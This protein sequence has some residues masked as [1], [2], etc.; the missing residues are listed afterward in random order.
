MLDW[1]II[2]ALTDPQIFSMQNSARLIRA[3]YCSGLAQSF[4]IWLSELTQGTYFI[5]RSN[6]DEYG[7]DFMI[8]NVTDYILNFSIIEGLT[9]NE[10]IFFYKTKD[11]LK[12]FIYNFEDR[13]IVLSPT[14]LTEGNAPSVNRAYS[15]PLYVYERE[16]KMKMRAGAGQEYTIFSTASHFVREI[17]SIQKDALYIFRYLGSHSPNVDIAL[18]IR[19]NANS[20]FLFDCTE[21]P[22]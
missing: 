11:Y 20:N 15:L 14:I 18:P 5:A 19:V 13:E 6:S 22:T 8:M 2:L 10:V 17:A 7:N 1:E 21:D 16:R 9:P 12:Y 4:A 3:V